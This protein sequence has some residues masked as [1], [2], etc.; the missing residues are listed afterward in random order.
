MT[1][2]EQTN[3]QGNFLGN[4]TFAFSWKPQ[5]DWSLKAYYQHM[6]EDHSMLVTQYRWRDGLWG[7]EATLPRNPV[8][9]DIVAE[10]LYFKD[11]TGPVYW[12]KTDQIPTQVSG[13]DG[14]YS[15]YMYGAWQ[16][17]GMMIGNPLA[18]SPVFNNHT[19]TLMSTRFVAWHLG[20]QGQPTDEIGYRL[21]AT[22]SRHWGTY[23]NPLPDVKNSF[24]FLAEVSWRPK[25]LA[26]WE[27]K[28]S[29]GADGGSLLGRNVGVG[30]SISK[31]GLIKF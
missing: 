3:V 22:F 6:F 8:V 17:W 25:K 4:W 26:G 13:R 28:F 30:I 11:Q 12:D 15:H 29:L 9:S 24:N 20:L 19:L 14:Y 2:S 1:S 7:L 18:V 31:T 16:N 21:K 5:A 23:A 10:F 27:G